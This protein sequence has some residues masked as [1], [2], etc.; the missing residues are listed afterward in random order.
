MNAIMGMIVGNLEFYHLV[1]RALER[2]NIPS[3]A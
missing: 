2:I 3:Y 1:K